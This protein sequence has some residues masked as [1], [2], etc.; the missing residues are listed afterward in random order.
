[1]SALESVP[2]DN[3]LSKISSL[4]PLPLS[5]VPDVLSASPAGDLPLAACLWIYEADIEAIPAWAARWRGKY[6]L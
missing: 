5:L 2:L 4:R 1:M 3:M 6:H